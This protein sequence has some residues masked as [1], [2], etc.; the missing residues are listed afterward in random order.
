MSHKIQKIFLFYE[1]IAK[2]MH[3]MFHKLVYEHVPAAV[4]SSL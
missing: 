4:R 1:D 2:K 3:Q